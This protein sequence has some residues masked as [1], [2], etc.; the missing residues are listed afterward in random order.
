MKNKISNTVNHVR[1]ESTTGSVPLKKG[2]LKIPQ[3]FTGKY[4][5]WGFFFSKLAGVKPAT[6]SKTDPGTGDFGKR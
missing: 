2:D 5:C 6:F 1:T 4:L 3:K